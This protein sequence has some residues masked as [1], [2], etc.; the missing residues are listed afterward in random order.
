MKCATGREA[1]FTVAWVGRFVSEPE[2]TLVTF[3]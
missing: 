1:S 2:W 3:H